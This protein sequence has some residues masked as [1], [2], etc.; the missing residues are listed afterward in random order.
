[1]HPSESAG[2]VE[3]KRP[4]I[5]EKCLLIAVDLNEIAA[6]Q[7]QLAELKNGKKRLPE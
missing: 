1:M 5:G 6:I 2:I 7:A 3:A 4:G